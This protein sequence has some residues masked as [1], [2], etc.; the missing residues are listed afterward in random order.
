MTKT[1]DQHINEIMDWFDFGRVSTVMDFLEWKWYDEHGFATPLEGELRKKSRVQLSKTYDY[2]VGQ[3][4]KYTVE[5]G[6]FSYSYDPQSDEMTILFILSSH[7]S[8][9]DT[10][11]KVPF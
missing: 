11:E 9:S 8:Y 10:E 4:R 6:G 7:F 1:K 2:A 3:G 5:T